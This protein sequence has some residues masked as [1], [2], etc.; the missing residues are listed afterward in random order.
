[1]TCEFYDHCNPP[2]P[3]YHIGYLPRIHAS[4]M[5]ELGELG[6]ESIH[7]I[8]D[9]FELSEIQRRAATCVQTGEPWFDRDGL[10]ARLATLRYPVAYLDFETINPAI[11]RFSGMRPFD[12][13]CF[14]FSLHIQ[15][16][17]GVALEHVE[18]LATDASDPRHEFIS[19]LC[20]AL[21][22]SGS[23]VVYSSFECKRPKSLQHGSLS[24]GNGST[25]YRPDCSICC[26]SC[27]NTLI[28]R[29]RRFV[30]DQI[31][32]ASTGAGDE[33]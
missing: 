31:S 24:S 19:S 17:L 29:I 21:G 28:I 20:A 8:P 25:R 27:G 15:R 18:F 2:R 9:D 33:L 16:D 7:D 12:H 11:P 10:A 22:E 1:V 32:S 5:E 26:L 4:A 30:F 3:D 13:I 6:V 14:Q 23:V